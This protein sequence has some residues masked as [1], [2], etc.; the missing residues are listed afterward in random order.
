MVN[1]E[2]PKDAVCRKTLADSGYCVIEP[3][4]RL[5]RIPGHDQEKNHGVLGKRADLLQNLCIP[6][7]HNLD[8]VHLVRVPAELV[9]NRRPPKPL[10]SLVPGTIP[11]FCVPGGSPDGGYTAFIKANA[12]V[13]SVTPGGS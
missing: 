9:A 10:K 13:T 11:K 2:V 8:Q 4:F 7:P 3:D 5:G 12:S 6:E 1:A